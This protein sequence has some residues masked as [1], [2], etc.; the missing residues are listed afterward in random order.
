MDDSSNGGIANE[1]FNLNSFFAR[2]NYQI[3][4]YSVGRLNYSVSDYDIRNSFVL[5]FVYEMPFHFQKAITNQA[6]SGWTV[7]YRSRQPFTVYN[8]AA[9]PANT[10]RHGPKRCP[11]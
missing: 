5:D 10:R 6:L 8:S 4:P 3:D 2:S 1:P 11:G 9:S 7:F